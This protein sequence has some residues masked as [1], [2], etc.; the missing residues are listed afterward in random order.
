MTRRKERTVAKA[1]KIKFPK[2]M[3][4]EAR[5]KR[6]GLPPDIDKHD[7]A[8]TVMLDMGSELEPR[9]RLFI[10]SLLLDPKYMDAVA[11][12][13][14][15][16]APQKR[17]RGKPTSTAAA[18]RADKIAETYFI[19]KARLQHA[20]HKEEVLPNVAGYFRVSPSYVDKVLKRL[21]PTRRAEMKAHAAKW[22]EA[23]AKW[24]ATPRGIEY[25]RQ[26]KKWKET[27]A[28]LLTTPQ[29]IE[30]RRLFDRAPARPARGTLK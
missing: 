9:E 4:D 15:G 6:L 12:A 19:E 1:E 5:R 3:D 28:K 14:P 21:D 27:F 26:N 16:L 22:G 29:G 30:Y 11:R 18:V 20:K 7:L 24:L 25:T 13:H 10:A 23:Y 2:K 8:L 17:G